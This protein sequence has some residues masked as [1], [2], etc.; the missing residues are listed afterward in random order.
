MSELRPPDF[1]DVLA[2]RR[3]LASRLLRTPLH[4][5]PGLC[6]LVG[7]EVRV[8]HE[9]HLPTGAFKVRGGL[10]RLHRLSQEQKARGVIA[11]S[12]GNH[13]QSLAFAGRKLGI[14][15]VIG[16]PEGANP[17][18]VASMRGLEAEVVERGANF[19]EARTLVEERARREG[20]T[21]IHH[22]LEPL[23]IA[24]VA[25]AY[26]EM[27][28]DEPDLDVII[29]PVGGGS[30]ACACLTVV[31]A[32][33]PS[34]EVIAVQAAGAPAVRDSWRLGKPQTRPVDTFAEGVATGVA[35]DFPLGIL[36]EGL[37]D[38]VLVSDEAMREAVVH[39]L[40]HAGCLVE[41]AGAASL[42][43]AIQLRDS[44]EGKR[45]GLMASGGNLSTETLRE[46]LETTSPSPP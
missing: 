1:A 40:H 26:L 34:V 27:L 3:F 18:K 11:A 2:A 32:L 4:R 25:T 36:R 45:V 7:T 46:I 44:L 19:D 38:F 43:A 20:L 28:E 31:Q 42:A 12:T 23:L 22:A 10:N 24:G 30:G 17:A 39:Y 33:K 16:V 41:T 21:Y 6:E 29:V 15:C 9:H 13:G 35:F 37:S 8:K 5:H 14:R